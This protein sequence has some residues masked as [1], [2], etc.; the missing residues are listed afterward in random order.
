MLDQVS[1]TVSLFAVMVVGST[2]IETVGGDTAVNMARPL[3]AP[4]AP[5]AAQGRHEKIGSKSSG[6]SINGIDL[7]QDAATR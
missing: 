4:P 1:L 7:R 5:A 6:L 3:A 2:L